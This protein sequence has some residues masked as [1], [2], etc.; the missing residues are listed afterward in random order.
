MGVE[1]WAGFSRGDVHAHPSRRGRRRVLWGSR[2]GR[3]R[4]KS[5]STRPP[6]DLEGVTVTWFDRMLL[7]AAGV[8]LVANVL[9]VFGLWMEATHA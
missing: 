3:L 2:M 6:S 4:A 9:F 5:R 7:R 8:V 1:Q